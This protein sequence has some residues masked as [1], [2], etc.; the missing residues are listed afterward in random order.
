MTHSS[1]DEDTNP[2]ETALN[3]LIA[4]QDA[5]DS[6]ELKAGFNAW[7]ASSPRHRTSWDEVQKVWSLLGETT[8]SRAKPV[9]PAAGMSAAAARRRL[10]RAAVFGIGLSALAACL[11]I[12]LLPGMLLRLEADAFTTV[13]ETRQITLEDGSRLHLAANSAIEIAYSEDARRIH[14]LTGTLFVEVTPDSKRPFTLV[15][16]GLESTALG[17]AYEVR[18]MKSGTMVSVAHGTVR[19]DDPRR[20]LP[21]TLKAGEWVFVSEDGV[22]ARRG[23]S[24]AAQIAAWRGGSLGVKDWPLGEVVHA[25]ARHF[26]GTILITDDRLSERRV[27]GVYDLADPVNALRAAAYP[28]ELAVRQITPW[29]L[30]VSTR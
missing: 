28:H 20:V 15:T 29:I 2:S 9:V 30:V 1:R 22:T 12:F 13:G 18:K 8:P 4:L 5:P 7:V 14:L 16:N 11:L 26:H 23:T 24:T 27:T 10:S 25:L 19:A 21:E 3:W 6:P 17:T